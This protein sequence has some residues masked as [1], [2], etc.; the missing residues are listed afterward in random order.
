MYI[1]YVYMYTKCTL[2]HDSNN[3]AQ[4]T[5]DTSWQVQAWGTLENTKKKNLLELRCVRIIHSDTCSMREV[6]PNICCQSWKQQQQTCT[7]T[8]THFSLPAIDKINTHHLFGTWPAKWEL[9]C[10]LIHLCTH[11]CTLCLIY[12]W[13]CLQTS[14]AM[15]W[16]LSTR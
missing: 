6:T 10:T 3:S 14:L 13:H 2:A 15:S 9:T 8:C 16:W 4:H 5:P 12:S 11:T 7:C 1:Y